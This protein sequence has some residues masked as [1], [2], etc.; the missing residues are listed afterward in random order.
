MA[1]EESEVETSLTNPRRVRGDQGE[2]EE[3]SA[4]EIIKTDIYLQKRGRSRNNILRSS[5]VKLSHYEGGTS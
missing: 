3:R 1:L 4:D 5:L 2:I